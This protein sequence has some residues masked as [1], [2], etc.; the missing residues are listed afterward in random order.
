MD[1]EEVS[2]ADLVVGIPRWAGA[3]AIWLCVRAGEHERDYPSA[4]R[5]H[6]LEARRLAAWLAG[7]DSDAQR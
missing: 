4:C 2:T 1:E 3:L 5:K 6:L 7:E